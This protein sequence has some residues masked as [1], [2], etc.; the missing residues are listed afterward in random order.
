MYTLQENTSSLL[1][2]DV[3][4]ASIDIKRETTMAQTSKTTVKKTGEVIELD[5][6]TPEAM[7]ESWALASEYIKAYEKIKD[8]IKMCIPDYLDSRNTF[9][10]NG[11]AFRLSNIQR[12][13]YD[14]SIMRNLMDEDMYDVFV[15]PDVAAIKKYTKENLEQLPQEWSDLTKNMVADGKPYEVIKL[16][17][18]TRPK[19]WGGDKV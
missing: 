13:T 10:H 3:A 14:K 1:T 17:R 11:Y 12:Y 18:L 8:E 2:C 4:S 7:V 6:S 5:I 9:E 15:K 19:E 16:E